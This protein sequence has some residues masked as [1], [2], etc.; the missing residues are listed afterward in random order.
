[1]RLA[2][3]LHHNA[4]AVMTSIGV[5]VCDGPRPLE[6]RPFGHRCLGD[7]L[8]AANDDKVLPG[9]AKLIRPGAGQLSFHDFRVDDPDSGRPPATMLMV[10]LD[11]GKFCADDREGLYTDLATTFE[12]AARMAEA[13]L[14]L[15]SMAA[16]VVTW[17]GGNCVD[18]KR[19]G[20]VRDLIKGAL[21][22]VGVKAEVRVPIIATDEA[23]IYELVQLRLSCHQNRSF[24]KVLASLRGG[25]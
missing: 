2:G 17:T 1:M 25:R 7:M 6:W 18:I 16:V 4:N 23:L 14:G 5:V 20:L 11:G 21:D 15:T 24:A 12:D 9:L 22:K 19:T 10:V 8:R 3:S 13:L